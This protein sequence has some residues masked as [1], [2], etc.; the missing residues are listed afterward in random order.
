MSRG[1]FTRTEERFQQL[2]RMR[3]VHRAKLLTAKTKCCTRCKEDLPKDAKNFLPRKSKS[4]FPRFSS[5][6]RWCERLREE[7]RRTEPVYK[8]YREKARK[9]GKRADYAKKYAQADPARRKTIRDRDKAKNRWRER[10]GVQRGNVLARRHFPETMVCATCCAAGKT[11]LSFPYG[12]LAWQYAQRVCQ[13]CRNDRHSKLLLAIKASPELFCRLPE[14]KVEWEKIHEERLERKRLYD[15]ELAIL[16]CRLEFTLRAGAITHEE[17]ADT[18][19]HW[20]LYDAP[21]LCSVKE[22]DETC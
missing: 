22:E 14:E 12:R 16:R 18:L 21:E 1:N 17:A 4:G 9:E 8:S 7:E 15:L 11:T 10:G 19:R 2:A 20:E 5:M 6:C 3:V 13:T